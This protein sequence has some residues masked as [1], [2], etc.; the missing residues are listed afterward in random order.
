MDEATEAGGI[1][2]SSGEAV[3]GFLS[4]IPSTLS[5]FFA[6]IG[7]GA[8]VNGMFDWAALVIGIALLLGAA[9]GI[10]RGRIVGPIVSG[11]IAVA[12]M[13]WAVS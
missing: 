5:D 12:M 2:Q 9:R 11:F 1:A 13:G 8:G 6:G 10:R 4:G 7:K 3:G